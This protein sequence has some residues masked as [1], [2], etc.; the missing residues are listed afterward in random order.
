MAVDR[1]EPAMKVSGAVEARESDSVAEHDAGSPFV[2]AASLSPSF[3]EG[4]TSASSDVPTL[5]I[6]DGPVP[7][8]GL[9]AGRR[10]R[11]FDGGLDGFGISKSWASAMICDGG[12]AFGENT[13]PKDE[14]GLSGLWLD[15]THS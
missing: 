1:G 7:F 10:E 11:A 8:R 13:I 14:E 6:G 3:A 9:P 5:R 12:F 15:I 4:L 2:G